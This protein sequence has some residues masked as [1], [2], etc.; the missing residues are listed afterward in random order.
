MGNQNGF[1]P[2]VQSQET[3]RK[4]IE[5]KGLNQGSQEK[6]K[7]GRRHG[8]EREKEGAGETCQTSTAV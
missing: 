2:V 8:E 3:N 7:L 6:G 1:W 5:K 4:G